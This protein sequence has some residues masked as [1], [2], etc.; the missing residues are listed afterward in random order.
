[1]QQ[2]K[3]IG[4]SK[5]IAL[6][7]IIWFQPN[8]KY[9]EQ[10]KAED[11]SIERQR[12]AKAAE[13]SRQELE[14]LFSVANET[15]PETAAIFEV[16][17]MMLIDPDFTDGVESLICDGWTAQ[18]SVRQTADRLIAQ[19]QT[20]T[21]PYFQAR[22]ADVEDIAQRV[23]RHLM[24]ATDETSAMHECGIIVADDLLPSQTV[25]FDRTK[26]KGFITRNGSYASHAAILARTMGVPCIV[27]VGEGVASIPHTGRIAMDG[28]SGEIV[29]EP[30]EQQEQ[31]FTR[32]MEQ[33][34]T[35]T[36]LLEQYRN[37]ET[38]APNGKRLLVCA[39]IGDPDDCPGVLEQ[40]AD[41]VGLFRSE[42]LYLNGTDFP[43]EETQF[44]A[45]RR[46]LEALAPKPVVIRTLDLGSDKQATYFSIGDEENPAL[47]YRAIRICLNQP[48]LF[49]TQLRA[50][51]R[52]SVYG[53][54]SILFPMISHMEQ[55][56][57]IQDILKET[58][59]ELANEGTAFSEDVMIGIMIETPAAA[60]LSDQLA[61][62]VDFFSIGTNDLTQY[63]LA[64]D[65]TN[66]R[67]N[68][69]FDYAHPAVLRLIELTAK[70]AHEK[71]IPVHICG[72]SAADTKLT[73]FYVS[74]GIDELSVAPGSIQEVRRAIIES[75]SPLEHG[76]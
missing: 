59:R 43:S 9:V 31:K 57:G 16:H 24:H 51:L 33:F 61:S 2:L 46:V 35:Q 68:G 73:D 67:V 4:A 45:Y 39:N 30:D 74:V 70:S 17:Q 23:I 32:L 1:M 20:C 21:D 15:D 50:L 36:K 72:E 66:P 44:L 5:G 11:S 25:L 37:V 12:F 26:I 58:R 76:R 60:L 40:N 14:A 18:W 22:A 38:I 42:F 47:G 41:G 71:G 49:K 53:K 10:K 62:E 6:D 48:D 8:G 7:N 29:V 69:L 75:K 55:I 63:T 65:R 56:H 19:L 28:E 3:G 52:A 64:V 54:L 34:D 27:G 13:E